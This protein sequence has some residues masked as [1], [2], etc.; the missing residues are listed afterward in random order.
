MEHTRAPRSLPCSISPLTCLIQSFLPVAQV[1]LQPFN[2]F[3]LQVGFP[4]MGKG[5]IILPLPLG[6]LG[7]CIHCCPGEGLLVEGDEVPPI[8]A[9]LKMALLAPVFSQATAVHPLNGMET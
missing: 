8:V 6:H 5:Q 9:K 1:L 3:P 4:V 2:T 7:C